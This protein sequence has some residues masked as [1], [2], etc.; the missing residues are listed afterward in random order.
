ML[1]VFYENGKWDDLAT[2]KEILGRFE[3][4]PH[5]KMAA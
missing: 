2:L 3:A 1:S 4:P 5:L